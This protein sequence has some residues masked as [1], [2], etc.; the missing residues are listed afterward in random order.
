MKYRALD[1]LTSADVE[2]LLTSKM[3][4]GRDLDYKRELPGGSDESKREFLSDV[5][6]FANSAGGI[7]LFG[8]EEKDGI[9]VSAPGVPVAGVDSGILRLE[10]LARDSIEERIPGIRFRAI[11]VSEATAVIVMAIPRSWAG[12]HLVSFKGG[13]R[14]YARNARGKYQMNLGELRRAFA[15]ASGDRDRMRSLRVERVAA[16]LTEETPLKLYGGPKVVL[17]V[18]PVSAL[19]DRP[20]IDVSG[21]DVYDLRF[22]AF[23]SDR[24]H[25]PRYN[26]DG[27][28][29]APPLSNEGLA[30]SY[31]QLF[32]TGVIEAVDAGMIHEEGGQK[33][34]WSVP[35]ERKLVHAVEQY[36]QTLEKLDLEG[37][38]VVMLSFTGVE[39]YRVIPE[40]R[41]RD[42]DSFRTPID[43]D[44]LLLPETVIETNQTVIADALRGPFD[45]LWQSA[46]W[47][48]S[49]NYNDQGAHLPTSDPRSR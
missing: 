15:Q 39:G 44:V 37:P 48:G 6:S 4:E 9:P 30:I 45:N 41:N 1:S 13:S 43:R 8:I 42:W 19:A 29:V 18:L 38:Y 10:N 28:A 25:D 32:R 12:P 21:I 49:Y 33:N 5:C 34:I 7:L 24:Y 22:A 20:Q 17:H 36:L 14:F 47:Q 31:A 26:F 3:P 27:V 23:G 11:P 2:Q 40:T 16:V 35:V 46:G